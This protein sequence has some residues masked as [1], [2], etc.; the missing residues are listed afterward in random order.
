M[1]ESFHFRKDL[2]RWLGVPEADVQVSI[3]KYTFRRASY[4]VMFLP[5]RR[6]G[7]E[8]DPEIASQGCQSN[9]QPD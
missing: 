4:L 6:V 8:W 9:T 5:R 1:L 2:A 3:L 7:A